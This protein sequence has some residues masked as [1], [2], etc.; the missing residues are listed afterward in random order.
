MALREGQRPTSNVAGLTDASCDEEPSDGAQM[1]E[2]L[3]QTMGKTPVDGKAAMRE[4]VGADANGA[5]CSR[6][7]SSSGTCTPGE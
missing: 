4:E 2:M 5:C 1:F 3:A 7:R 6:Y